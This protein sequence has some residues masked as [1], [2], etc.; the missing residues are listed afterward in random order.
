LRN[1]EFTSAPPS[2]PTAPPR[3]W[4]A[5]YF[6]VRT[7]DGQLI[8]LGG[9]V[10]DITDRKRFEE[11]LQRTAEFR[12]RFLGI[13]GHDLRGPLQAIKLTAATL[14][15]AEDLPDRLAKPMARVASSAEKMFRMISELLDFT[16]GRLGGGIPIAPRPVDLR[17]VVRGVV[18]EL[19]VTRPERELVLSADGALEG[20]WDPDRLE[21]VVANLVGNALNYSPEGTPVLIRLRGGEDEVVL[22]VTNAGSIPPELLPHIFDPFRRGHAT[23]EL[24]PADGLGLG[25]YIVQHV[26]RAH[27]GTIGVTS[28]QEDGTTFRVRLPRKPVT[29]SGP[30]TGAEP[31]PPPGR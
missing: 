4:L 31:A 1:F 21:Q 6:P 26:V 24:R 8:G 5:N 25:L 23:A 12:E 14:L 16:R 20:E 17:R 27:G 18:E 19:E 29:P 2:M 9:L 30:D 13:V 22:S 10:S 15:K 28:T 7:G 11:E 3:T